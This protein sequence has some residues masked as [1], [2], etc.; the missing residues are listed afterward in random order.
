MAYMGSATN[1]MVSS[2]GVTRSLDIKM[3]PS[4]QGVKMSPFL[5]LVEPISFLL[6]LDRR[7]RQSRGHLT[8]IHL[9]ARGG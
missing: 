5:G 9:D 4:N 8:F 3:G 7:K 6:L 1:Y 2:R